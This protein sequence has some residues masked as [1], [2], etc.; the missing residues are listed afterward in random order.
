[1]EVGYPIA[2]APPPETYTGPELVELST[3]VDEDSWRYSRFALPWLLFCF[4]CLIALFCLTFWQQCGDIKNLR[5]ARPRLIQLASTANDSN[6]AGQ[7][8]TV[9]NLRI[10][11]VWFGFI[12]A[13]L[14]WLIFFFRPGPKTRMP[15]NYLCVLLLFICGC[16]AWIAFGVG[17][18]NY[19]SQQQCPYNRRFTAQHCLY[20]PAYAITNCALDAGVGVASLIAAILLAYNTKANHWRLAARDWEE[21]QHDTAEPTKERMPGEMVQRNVSTVRKF[22]TGLAL[23]AT[24]ILVIADTVF[25]I[26]LHED[27]E[28]QVLMGPRGR[29]DEKQ[30]YASTLPFEHP[31]WKTLNTRLRYCTVGFGIL[32][33]LLNFLPFRSKTIAYIFGYLYI[34]TATMAMC[35]FGFDVREMGDA[36]DLP[37]PNAPDG[38][39]QQ[40]VQASFIATCVLDIFVSIFLMF[41]V[42]ME[43]VF[44]Q[45]RQCQHCDRAFEINELV[46]HE[47]SE[48]PCRPVRCEVCAK[49]MNF[50]QFE[51][52][53][54]YCSIDHVRCKHCGSMVAK[55]GVKAHQEECTRWPIQCTMCSETF[56]RT[57]MPHHVMVCP[58]RPTS[59]DT[60]GETFRSRDMDAHR[61]VCGEVLVQC[62]LCDDQMQ[63]FRL[64]QHQHHECP[65]RL[66][67]CD[68]CRTMIPMFQW[69]RHQQR[70]C[71]SL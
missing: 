37:C 41:Y 1:M 40:C 66:Q 65:K 45:I 9:K 23:I 17:L 15:L 14:A 71:S 42:L 44:L 50:K 36:K 63:R 16:L 4:G 6:E 54:L 8:R 55:W 61:T 30:L 29:A 32:T 31:G 3:P 60:C 21:A 27:R 43:Y 62:E 19:N 52:H 38:A 22:L 69:E 67:E 39:I 24:L 51:Q 11:H 26:L 34:A 28:K 48:C 70:D 2:A 58:N 64:Q 33:V 53:K 57:D 12:G 5:N 18:A 49:S 25:I 47:S 59:C 46:K 35:A 20:H 10:A 7:P 56:Q 68:R 13:I